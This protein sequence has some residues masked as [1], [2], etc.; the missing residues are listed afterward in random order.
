MNNVFAFGAPLISNEAEEERETERVLGHDVN[1]DFVVELS[2]IVNDSPSPRVAD[3]MLHEVTVMFSNLHPKRVEEEERERR[4]FDREAL[5]LVK[6]T[7]VRLSDPGLRSMT[8]EGFELGRLNEML[9]K[10]TAG[11]SI[12]K[13]EEAIPVQLTGSLMPVPDVV[14]VVPDERDT[15][16]VSDA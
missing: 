3:I 16:V 13:R 12:V 6:E 8:E 9:L 2:L 4:D 7:R 5:S 10:V 11:P 15:V 14:M 1:D